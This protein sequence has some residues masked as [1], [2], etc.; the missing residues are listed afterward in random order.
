MQTATGVAPATPA[1]PTG[2]LAQTG[3]GGVCVHAVGAGAAPT[4]PPVGTTM[5]VEGVS[6]NGVYVD[7][8][9][10]VGVRTFTGN[11]TGVSAIDLLNGTGVSGESLTGV[12][13]LGVCRDGTA[14]SGGSANGIGVSGGSPGGGVGVQALSGSVQPTSQSNVGVFAQSHSGIGVRAVGGGASP[15]TA[16]PITEGAI[17]A[18]AGPGTGVY[19][20]TSSGIG[21]EANS[22]SGTGVS[23]ASASG[24][25]VQGHSDTSTGVSGVTES[26]FGVTADGGSAGVA[27][28]V[29]GKVEVQGNS[30]GSVAMAAGTKTLK[31]NNAAATANSLIFLT[32]LEDPQAFLWIGARNAGSF[33]IDT[34]KALP[35][36]VTIVFLIIN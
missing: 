8:G 33:T 30:V 31:V 26:G 16:A 36:K 13:V 18:E 22:Q 10:N 9:S 12:G 29:I 35:D 14:V 32:P 4:A 25:G 19:A 28:Q 7:G 20:S 15:A 11:G 21:V 27:L 2:V 3:P 5:F 24:P 6:E 34:S 1:G 23:A 17:L